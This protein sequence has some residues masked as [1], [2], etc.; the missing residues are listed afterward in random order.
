MRRNRV[1]RGNKG[2]P[3]KLDSRPSPANRAE[4]RAVSRDSKGS[5]VVFK[6]D[7]QAGDQAVVVWEHK[8]GRGEARE[9]RAGRAS[10]GHDRAR[11]RSSTYWA[12]T[13]SFSHF[14][15]EWV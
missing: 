14:M 3:V 9:D 11:A 7:S 13:V 8:E 6:L 10:L 1:R 2:R 5:P 4:P 12:R 15:L